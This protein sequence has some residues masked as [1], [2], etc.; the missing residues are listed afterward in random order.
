MAYAAPSVTRRAVSD[1]N[2]QRDRERTR[3]KIFDAAA[4]VFAEKG[5]AGARVEEIARR[6]GVNR[7]L[8]SYYFEGKEGLYQAVLRYDP[9]D[10]VGVDETTEVADIVARYARLV[11]DDPKWVRLLVWDG[12][13]DRMA[14]DEWRAERYRMD[15][16]KVKQRQQSG[17]VDPDL[18]P[19]LTFFAVHVLTMA[20]Y[21]F[22]QIARMLSGSDP[23]S[24][25]FRER[26]EA[27][28]RTV[29]DRIITDPGARQCAEP[30][31]P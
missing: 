5:F 27:F 8:I 7:Q 21:I 22:P 17:D 11:A 9:P 24:P 28:V 31:A 29:T 26:Y 3:Q 23:S 4:E 20:P 14:D 30:S 18:D 2:R 13:H 12:L 1:E 10:P 16:A 15:V 25:E 19:G 6:A